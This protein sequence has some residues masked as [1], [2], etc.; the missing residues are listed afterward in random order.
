ML[1][2]FLP[3]IISPN[4][5]AFVEMRWIVENK[6]IAHELVHKVRSIRGEMILWSSKWNLK[7]LRIDLNGH[8][9]IKL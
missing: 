3:H 7:K 1:K 9:W 2:G 6:V 4:Q 5:G 8:F